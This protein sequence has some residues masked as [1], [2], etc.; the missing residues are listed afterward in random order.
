VE[1][2]KLATIARVSAARAGGIFISK[3]HEQSILIAAVTGDSVQ[4]SETL[5]PQDRSAFYWKRMRLAQDAALQTTKD[6]DA[7]VASVQ[8]AWRAEN[9]HLLAD[10]PTVGPG[11]TEL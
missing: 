2:E 10:V 7:F 3:E 1:Q 6:Y 5:L 8:A 4:A 9:P 11:D